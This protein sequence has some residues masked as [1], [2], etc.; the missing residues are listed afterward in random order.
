M[1]AIFTYKLSVQVAII[2][3][4]F[5]FFC[6]FTEVELNLYLCDGHGDQL[7]S[8]GLNCSDSALDLDQSQSSR[9]AQ[10]YTR[11]VLLV[12]PLTCAAI[13]TAILLVYMVLWD[14]QSC[15]G[16]SIMAMVIS[17]LSFYAGVATYPSLFY[18]FSAMQ[19]TQLT[20]LW[21]CVST[22][23]LY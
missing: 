18:A 13:D 12:G 16:W 10:E 7:Q 4:A 11:L 14:K 19:I 20:F 2:L 23:K 22:S 15:Y 6:R 5:S 8:M 9:T 3:G 21:M 1:N 17:L